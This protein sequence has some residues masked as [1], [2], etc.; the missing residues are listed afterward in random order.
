[1][2]P[3]KELELILKREVELKEK[4][5]EIEK[6]AKQKRKEVELKKAII[7]GKYVQKRMKIDHDYNEKVLSILDK[8]I[9]SISERKILGLD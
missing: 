1:M 8:D 2:N 6:K 7:I 4:R 9:K 3:E 5:K